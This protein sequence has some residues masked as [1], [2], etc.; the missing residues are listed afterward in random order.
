MYPQQNSSASGPTG[1]VEVFVNVT[2]SISLDG[3]RSDNDLICLDAIRAPFDLTD[4]VY[5]SIIRQTWC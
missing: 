5:C 1:C 4:Q 3:L 2:L